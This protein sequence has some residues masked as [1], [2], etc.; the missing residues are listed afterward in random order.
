MEIMSKDPVTLGAEDTAERCA[1]LMRDKEIGSVVVVDRDGKAVGI[2]T[3]RDLVTKVVAYDRQ[4]HQVKLKDIMSSPLIS[5]HPHAEVA[6][7]AKK[8]SDLRI[9]RLP[10]LD[11]GKLVGMVTENDMLRFF[12]QLAEVTREYARAGLFHPSGAIEG[13]CD[14]CGVYSKELLFDGKMTTCP[15]CR[16]R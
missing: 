13:H 6:E 12:P 16:E 8:M 4:S 14:V 1:T 15:E 10:V 7:A 11:E 9:R 2:V 3:E 5:V